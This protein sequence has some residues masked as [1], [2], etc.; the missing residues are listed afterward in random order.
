VFLPVVSRL[1]KNLTDFSLYLLTQNFECSQSNHIQ[2]LYSERNRLRVKEVPD[3]QN[4]C[5]RRKVL[6]SH[7]Q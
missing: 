6:G 1:K 4:Y 3:E 2:I 5:W 7:I